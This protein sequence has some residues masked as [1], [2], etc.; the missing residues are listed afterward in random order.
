MTTVR[1]LKAIASGVIPFVARDIGLDGQPIAGR[2]RCVLL[3]V[4]GGDQFIRDTFMPVSGRAAKGSSGD[5]AEPK[6]RTIFTRTSHETLLPIGGGGR[7]W[8][9]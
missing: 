6:V 8:Q 9:C 7:R 4:A 1:T 5:M 3:P 2:L